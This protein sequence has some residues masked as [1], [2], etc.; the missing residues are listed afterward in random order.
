MPYLTCPECGLRTYCVSGE[1]CP[2]CGTALLGPPRAGLR[3]RGQAATT[4]MTGGRFAPVVAV[5]LH[6]LRMDIAF[7]S[8]VR[9]G[10][11]IVISSVG[12][13]PISS[14]FAAGASVPLEETICKHLLD[15]A[16][17]GVVPDV[18]GE[19]LLRDLPFVRATG[20]R[21]YIGVSLRVA[22][23]R[24]YVMCC[25]ALQARPDLGEGDLR[26]LEGLVESVR[27]ALDRMAAPS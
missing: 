16:I 24:L 1:E 19:A 15:R 13:G 17:E 25:M 14:V 11:E 23:A 6:E 10:H 21:A 9:D 4:A 12:S 18:A 20:M 22:G 26:F 3:S 2:R 8:E 5:A 27:P 7:L